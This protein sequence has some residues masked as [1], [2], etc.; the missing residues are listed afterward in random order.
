VINAARLDDSQI[1]AQLAE[2]SGTAL[3]GFL[4]EFGKHVT[5]ETEKWSKVIKLAG[6]NRSDHGELAGVP[7]HPC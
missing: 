4:A 3:M 1:K 5:A 6:M 2:S 7:Q